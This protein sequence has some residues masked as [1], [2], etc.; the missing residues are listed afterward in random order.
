VH[1]YGCDGTS[2]QQYRR[3]EILDMAETNGKACS[4]PLNMTKPC[5]EDVVVKKECAEPRW[6]EWSECSRTCGGGQK[7]RSR[8]MNEIIDG[9][10]LPQ[11]LPLK[12]INTCNDIECM[13]GIGQNCKLSEWTDWG[14]CSSKDD[15]QMWRS[16]FV[17][18]PAMG[19]GQACTGNMKETMSCESARKRDCSFLNWGEW[20]QCDVQCGGGQRSR[21]R[22]ALPALM[23]GM[24]CT[25]PI[26]IVGPCNEVPCNPGMDCRMTDWQPW[27][28]C[29]PQCGAGSRTRERS[30]LQAARPG[31]VGCAMSMKEVQGCETPCKGG[32]KDCMWGDWEEWGACNKAIKCGVG[33]RKRK[34][35]IVIAPQQGGTPCEALNPEE[36]ASSLTCPGQC[37]QDCADTDWA[38]W[39]QWGA[40]S[41]TCGTGMRTRTRD[42]LKG[43]GGKLPCGPPATGSFNDIEGCA[44]Q[45]ACP[46]VDP[47]KDCQ[48]S[49][50]HDWD[51]AVC[52]AKCNGHR[53]R[54]RTIAK[55]AQPGGMA[56]AGALTASV[57]C[58]PSAG[59]PTPAD[60]MIG[61]PRDCKLSGWQPWTP[62]K[63]TC[64]EGY[65][66]RS[67]EVIIPPEY[68]GSNCSNPL[69]EVRM[70]KVKD[71]PTRASKNCEWGF[72]SE[73]SACDSMTG[74]KNRMRH[75]LRER[76]DDGKECE[77]SDFEMESCSRLCKDQ[78][79]LCGFSVWDQWSQ[80]S[81][82]CGYQGRVTRERRLQLFDVGSGGG[83]YGGGGS[84]RGGDGGGDGGAYGGGGTSFGGDGTSYGGDGTSYG[85]DGASAYGKA[86]APNLYE[87]KVQ[88]LSAPLADELTEQRHGQV[89]LFAAFAGGGLAVAAVAGFVRAFSNRG[90]LPTVE[91]S[92]DEGRFIATSSGLP[93]LVERTDN[94]P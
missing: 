52:T 41:S 82:P 67:R 39:R 32:R 77:G 35:Q 8:S 71:C 38:S 20:G 17:E 37:N 11:E 3:R 29:D 57:R 44:P 84:S 1:W 87:G 23:G 12:E 83:S 13:V 34:R 92:P 30:I 28:P 7:E 86:P 68:G 42:I 69:E 91:S 54:F 10:C 26:Y 94:E 16:R 27:S 53:T 78:D 81:E 43:L 55:E 4:G 90:R 60:C 15:L 21:R 56:C 61:T 51:Q 62:C 64:G 65:K 49:D 5:N 19:A 75:K 6:G 66:T 80:C 73:W 89:Q 88:A 46:G 45:S 93:L 50:W 22:D 74:E 58:N 24:P 76:I 63:A 72:W 31:G 48:F 9:N 85:G 40:C 2:A 36:V 18:V 79:Y 47:L 70:C 25:G 14:G 33:F 59:G